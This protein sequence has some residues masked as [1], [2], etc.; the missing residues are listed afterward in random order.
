MAKDNRNK[1]IYVRKVV[2]GKRRWLPIGE[3][4][5]SR[6]KGGAPWNLEYKIVQTVPDKILKKVMNVDH[7]YVNF[8]DLIK[9]YDLK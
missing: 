2:G 4:R 5:G 9:Y 7:V 3:V 8:D 6:V 1:K